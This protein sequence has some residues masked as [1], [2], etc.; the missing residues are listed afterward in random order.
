MNSRNANRNPKFADKDEPQLIPYI[1]FCFQL[2]LNKWY[3]F[4][5]SVILCVA[6]GWLYQQCS[7]RI[8]QRQTVMLIENAETT[9]PTTGVK[10]SSRNNN[11][12]N[13]MELNGISVGDNLKNEIFILSSTRLMKQVVDKLNLHVDYVM[14]RNLHPVSL[15]TGER[16]FEI[17]F[18]G[19]ELKRGVQT[20]TV[21]RKDAHT[22][23]IEDMAD[24]D[25]ND[26]P[27]M[28]V[29]IGQ[30]ARSPYGDLCVVRGKAFDQW[31]DEEVRVVRMS[32]TDA[33]AKYLSGFTASEYDKETSLIV[34]TCRD[35]DVRRA[36]DIL[37]TLFDTYKED[38]VQNKNQVAR[39]TAAFIDERIR[40]IESELS[41][42]ESELAGFKKRNQMMDFEQTAA[43]VATQVAEAQ[44]QSIEAE[45]QL[46][47]AKYL[48]DYVND[49]KTVNDLIPAIN[50]GSQSFNSQ[51]AAYNEL[52]AKR[53]TVATNTA[54]DH[55]VLRDM[56]HQLAQM[57]QAIKTSLSN[58]VQS[59]ELQ[60]K[61][62]RSNEAQLGSVVAGAPEQEREGIDIQRRQKLKESLYT[63]LMNKR[64]EVALQQAISEANVR[65]VEGPIGGERKV[66]PRT[67]MILFVSLMLGLAIPALILWLQ[68]ALDVTVHGRK[69]VEESTNLPILGEIPRLK[70]SNE[71]SLVTELSGDAPI[72]EAFRIL[73]FNMGYLRHS[74]QVILVT[75]ATPGQGK[76]FTSRNLACIMAMAQKRVLLIDAD[77]RKRT[78]SRHFGQELGLT[79]YLAD[80]YCKVDEIIQPDGLVQGVDFMAAGH[81]PPNPAELLMSDRL[82]KLVEELRER[83]DYIIIDGTPLIAVADASVVDRVA[84]MTLFVVRVGMQRRDF[85]PEL[86][87]IYAEDR[88]SNLCIVINDS[89]IKENIYGSQAGYG[90]GYGYGASRKPKTV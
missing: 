1:K 3:W 63:Y 4:A 52:M 46:S 15:Y 2:F 42:V 70:K 86:E 90:Y 31:E 64:E 69:D 14:T 83:Y 34:L 26:L 30:T 55:T 23:R 17:L 53:N 38:V 66:S 40:I 7:P 48:A 41:S 80:E 44:K 43:T 82:E 77:I 36:D 68:M 57:R 33:A 84:D 16:P 88:L 45:T 89:D 74:T 13:L 75:S 58:Y 76:S 27:D 73:R 24:Q 79:T 11:L 21:R 60:V 37:S 20:M 49:I 87:R 71:K 22:V 65:L 47:V 29:M 81:R 32:T 72:V 19:P 50:V 62:A 85:L 78:L 39:S 18:Q 10:R 56:D 61:A 8:Y 6:A 9:S 25:G 54:A 35:M 59:L 67:S 51:I 28:E 12:T 5:L